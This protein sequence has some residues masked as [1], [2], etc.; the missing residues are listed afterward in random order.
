VALVADAILD[1]SKRNG[2]VLDA[3]AGSGSTLVAAE[4]TRRRGF[5]IEIDPIYCD[6]IVKR[7]V[8]GGLTARLESS[9]AA[10]EQVAAERKPAN[11]DRVEVAA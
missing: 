6:V 3:F 9:G 4:K 5:G 7:L 11:D 1:A 8:A 10:F 2:I